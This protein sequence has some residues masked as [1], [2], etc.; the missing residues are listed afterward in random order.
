M[1]SNNAI[2]LG[3]KPSLLA[4]CC[5]YRTLELVSSTTEAIATYSSQYTLICHGIERQIL[6]LSSPTPGSQSLKIA[7]LKDHQTSLKRCLKTVTPAS[8]CKTFL[9]NRWPFPKGTESCHKPYHSLLQCKLYISNS[10]S[11][12]TYSAKLY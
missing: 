6:D 2:Y 5:Y 8:H 11:L 7:Q 1:D 10:H 3:I 9:R 12:Q 4:D